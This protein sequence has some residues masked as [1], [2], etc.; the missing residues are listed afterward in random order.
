RFRRRFEHPGS[1]VREGQHEARPIAS[2]PNQVEANRATLNPHVDD[3]LV[4]LTRE[5]VS[6]L[7]TRTGPVGAVCESVRLSGGMGFFLAA[8]LLEVLMLAAV[9]ARRSSWAH[10]PRLHRRKGI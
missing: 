1:A 9:P 3:G 4:E 10:R 2:S 7:L 5:Q 6:R 8:G